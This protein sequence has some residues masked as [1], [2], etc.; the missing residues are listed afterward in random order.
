M[1]NLPRITVVTPSYNQGRYLEE[2]IESVLMQ[3]YPN[4]EY[5]VIDGGSTDDSVAIIKKYSD[6]MKYWI[7]E[8]DRGQ[9]HAINKGL[10][11]ATG[12]IM[13]W[14]NSDDVFLPGA[15]ACMGE[16]FQRSPRVDVL[17]GYTLLVDAEKRIEKCVY[18]LIKF[19]ALAKHGVIPFSQQSMFWRRELMNRAGY[20]DES[21]QTSMDTD[22]WIRFLKSG[23][24]VRR[25][26]RYCAA[27]RLHDA[28]KSV[29]FDGF[30]EN[31]PPTAPS[32]ALNTLD[33]DRLLL[34][35]RH[36]DYRYRNTARWARALYL[37]GK[38]SHGD[39]LRD[40]LFRIKWK[41]QPLEKLCASLDRMQLHNSL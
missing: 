18:N 3:R 30:S 11:Q 27:W 20:L 33:K 14:L 31:K 35:E 6:K 16:M 29:A 28:C 39:Y 13:C 1:G 32:A 24:R 34:R 4:L 17:M 36:K 25:I 10:R 19:T 5:F 15:L 2:T 26:N 41:N 7:S 8:P 40:L 12:E 23:A 38:L 9:S 21:L 37:I 22:L